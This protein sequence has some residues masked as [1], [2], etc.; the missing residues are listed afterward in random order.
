MSS[1][2]ERDELPNLLKGGGEEREVRATEI[3]A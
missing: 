3:E 2:H 1:P